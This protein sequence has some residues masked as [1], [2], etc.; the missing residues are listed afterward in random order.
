MILNGDGGL[1]SSSNLQG[2]DG[3]N[4]PGYDP[5]LMQHFSQVNNLQFYHAGPPSGN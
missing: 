3:N 1:A 2:I 5:G 4:W